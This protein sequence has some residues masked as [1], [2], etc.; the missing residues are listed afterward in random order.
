[1]TFSILGLGSKHFKKGWIA[2]VTMLPCLVFGMEVLSGDFQTILNTRSDTLTVW[3]I[4]DNP[5]IFVFDFPGLATQGRTFNRVTQFTE[6]AQANNGYPRVLDNEEISKYMESLRRTQSNFAFG[7]DL[8]V[9]ELVQFFNL[10]DRDKIEIFPEEIA[11]RDFLVQ[12]GLIK[13]WRGFYQA[14]Q[15]GVVVLSI[16]QRQAKKVDEPQV[17]ELARTAIFTHEISHGEYYTNQYYA[18]YCRRFWNE[19][20]NDSEREAFLSLFKK[21]NYDVTSGE[22]VINEMQAYLMFTPDANSFNASKLGVTEQ[23][24]D[25]MRA[26]FRQGNPPT[27][28]PLR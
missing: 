5:K 17:S 25:A 10:I 14:L 21:Y 16:P 4:A 8:L 26:M 12:Q 23:V 2:A 18:A 3:N 24:L 20:L 27:K 9:S 1:M 13:T 15:P 22:L 28:L 11:L 7:H 6:Q 19:S